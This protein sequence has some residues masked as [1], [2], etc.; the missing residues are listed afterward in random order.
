MRGL[1]LRASRAAGNAIATL[2]A[3]SAFAAHAGPYGPFSPDEHY[4][5]ELDSCENVLD[6]RQ[7]H[8]PLGTID[9][10]RADN[11]RRLRITMAGV[12]KY[13]AR[14]FSRDATLGARVNVNLQA[15]MPFDVGL[16]DAI[17]HDLNRDGA[18]DFVVTFS[19]NGNGLG[20]SFYD[21][22]IA[23]SARDHYRFWVVPTMGPAP[24]DFVTFGPL[25]PIVMVTREFF[26]MRDW[27]AEPRS[28]FIYD[29][30]A[31]RGEEIVIANSV[32]SRFPKW[33]RYTI[34]PNWKPAL[35]VTGD[36]K[37]LSGSEP[38]AIEVVP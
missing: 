32:D 21:R 17:C 10:S 30:W 7:V 27:P 29:L 18:L 26:Q 28:Y 31:F 33:V 24:E 25:E 2:V 35:S 1:M 14:V 34:K 12:E 4:A 11:E 13:E 16:E 6:I 20:A 3:T 8:P 37:R 9:F 15:T 22:L 36:D 23:L 19:R 38:R 5:I